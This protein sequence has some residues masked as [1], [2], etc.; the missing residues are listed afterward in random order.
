MTDQTE[1]TALEAAIKTEESMPEAGTE[2]GVSTEDNESGRAVIKNGEIVIRVPI[3][4]LPVIVEGSWALN[5]LDIRYKITDAAL[6]ADDLVAALNDED[7]VGSTVIHNMFDKAINEAI[8][9]GAEGIEEHED[10]DA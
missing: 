4:Y 7:E 1:I 2:G 6:F 9:Q 8:N 10:Q 3:D 5:A